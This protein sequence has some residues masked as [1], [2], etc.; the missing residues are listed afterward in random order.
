MKKTVKE[1]LVIAGYLLCLILLVA[2]GVG[3]MLSVPY[4]RMLKFN[5]MSDTKITLWDA[6]FLDVRITPDKKDKH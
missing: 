1:V 4:M 3:A 2:L 6:M 5:E